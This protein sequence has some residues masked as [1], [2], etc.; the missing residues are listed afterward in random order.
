MML[1]FARLARPLALI[2]ACALAPGC[3]HL[4][5]AGP[6]AERALT[7]AECQAARVAM[8]EGT[9]PVSQLAVTART[10]RYGKEGRVRGTL[11][12]VV[13]RPDRFR[14]TV[15]SPHGPP[16]YVMACDGTSLTTYDVAHRAY[17]AQPATS[18]GLAQVLGGLDVGL[19]ARDWVSLFLG[20]MVVPTGAQAFAAHDGANAP[21]LW[22]WAEGT[23]RYQ[24]TFDGTSK[25][26]QSTRI[27]LG[28]GREGVLTVKS[29]DAH[30]WPD[31]L[32]L[33]LTGRPQHPDE[34]VD[35]EIIMSDVQ[36]L[37]APP[38][39]EA[40]ALSQPSVPHND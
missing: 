15:Q 19:A 34:A 31:I 6:A 40:F 33:R 7:P 1:P 27:A 8:S 17:N 21:I 2:T 25:R 22:R 36:L 16:V 24:A 20:E 14:V 39:D 30:H 4:N 12:I 18:V 38:A 13:S 23:R 10:T 32:T 5:G 35:L 3:A 11:G 29:R 9:T 28:D 26:W 37:A